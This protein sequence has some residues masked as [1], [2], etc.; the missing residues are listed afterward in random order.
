MK[1][2]ET[3][4][5]VINWS[6]N[7]EL[8]QQLN[9]A[10]QEK[11]V[12]KMDCQPFL[13]FDK[14]REDKKALVTMEWTCGLDNLI[15]YISETRFQVDYNNYDNE[16]YVIHEIIAT[17]ISRAAT[18]FDERI[19]GITAQQFVPE[20]FTDQQSENYKHLHKKIFKRLRVKK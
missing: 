6:V 12:I 4:F 11:P 13:N 7:K 3:A 14:H 2:Q 5:K 19:T 16:V 17:S 20:F 1:V 9:Y 10:T 18:E 8:H 15:E